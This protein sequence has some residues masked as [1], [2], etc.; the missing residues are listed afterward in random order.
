[1]AQLLLKHLTSPCCATE[2][3]VEDV[4][5]GP[6]TAVVV[7]RAVEVVVVAGLV[8]VVALVAAV[9]VVPGDRTHQVVE[10][11]VPG[12]VARVVVV[13][14]GSETKVWAA[15]EAVLVALVVDLV[16][17]V[18]SVP[19]DRIHQVVERVVLPVESS[20]IIT[21]LSVARVVVVTTLLGVGRVVVSDDDDELFIMRRWRRWFLSLV[22]FISLGWGWSNCSW[23]MVWLSCMSWRRRRELRV[24][25]CCWLLFSSSLE[26][27]DDD[28]DDDA[29][30]WKIAPG[31]CD[32]A[33]RQRRV[34]EET[35]M[36]K[37]R[38]N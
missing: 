6:A 1:M 8:V 35:F 15:V 26:T 17:G 33:T 31:C 32:I 30:A 9:E 4:V 38:W 29:A 7:A 19:G 18:G 23:S 34:K 13:E 16:V 14:V 2:V 24:I 10:R 22:S 11:V 25:I 28:D 36:V 21:W 5:V 37:K 27:G 20:S 12:V 3:E